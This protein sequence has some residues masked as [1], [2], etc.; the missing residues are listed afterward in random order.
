[1][2][3]SARML[4]WFWQGV[5]LGALVA[6]G[7]APPALRAQESQGVYKS[8]DAQGH[9]VYSDRGTAKNAPKTSLRVEEA[10]PTE[11]ARLAKEQ[12]A[13]TAADAERRKQQA[14]ED[15]AHAAADKKKDDACRNARNQYNRL[16]TR[17]PFRRDADGNRVYYTDQEADALREQ[18]RKAMQATCPS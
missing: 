12:Q 14:A 11:A 16:D 15:K 18:A 4:G 7:G 5:M 17:A 9:L 6:I 1:M 2:R 8:V 3:R 10:N 13:L